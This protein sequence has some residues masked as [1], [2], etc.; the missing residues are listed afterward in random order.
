MTVD[1]QDIEWGIA[2]TRISLDAM[3]SGTEQFMRRYYEFPQ[4]L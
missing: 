3:Y 4:F 1:R 2:L